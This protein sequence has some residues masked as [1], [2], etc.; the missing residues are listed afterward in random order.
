MRNRQQPPICPGFRPLGVKIAIALVAFL[1]ISG[2]SGV[3]LIADPSGDAIGL[4]PDLLEGLPISDYL[5]VGVFLFLVYGVV[6]LVV[7]YGLWTRKEWTWTRF[8][9]E[10]THQ[11]WSWT[12]ALGLGVILL[13][14]VIAQL[15][16]IGE[17]DALQI[18]YLALGLAIVGVILLPSVKRHYAE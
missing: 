4:P 2:I 10:W 3:I 12:A 8:L 11:H 9:S 1:A 7:L 6:S 16:L 14:W 15:I 17:P 18:L 13:I 5:L